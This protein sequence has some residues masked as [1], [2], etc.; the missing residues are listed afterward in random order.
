VTHLV[1]GH[2]NARQ[3]FVERADFD[4]LPPRLPSQVL[5]DVA[6]FAYCTGMRKGEICR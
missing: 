3:G 2:A 5:R 6:A 1:K 4:A